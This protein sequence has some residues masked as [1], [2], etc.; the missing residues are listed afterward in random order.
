MDHLAALMAALGVLL[1][2]PGA[3][4]VGT[5]W[6]LAWAALFRRSRRTR[7]AVQ[8]SSTFAILIPAH[9]EEGTLGATLDACRSLDYPADRFSIYVIADN[10]ADCTAE[11]ARAHGVECFERTDP[12][13]RGKGYA[14]AY[15]LER[16]DLARHDAVVVLDADC[17]IDAHAL[18]AFDREGRAGGPV[19]QASYRA[20]NPDASVISYALAVGNCTENEL[21]YAPKSALGGVVLLRGT[22]MVLPRD[23]LRR[24]P[25]QA[26][27]I[28]EDVE[29]AVTLLRGGIRI[30]FVPDVA[31]HSAFPVDREQLR[32]QRTRWASGNLGFARRNV[33]RLMVDGWRTGDG[34]LWD[35]GATFLILSR[36]LVLLALL[37]PLG[38]AV[39][40]DIATSVRL[41]RWVWVAAAALLALLLAYFAL[42]VLRLGLTRRRLGLLLGAPAVLLQLA[43]I[44]VAGLLRGPART[45]DRTPRS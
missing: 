36:P 23:V 4:I 39:A 3:A 30:R 24:F 14:L 40:G 25:W 38:L 16:I 32:V 20:S 22:G 28:V 13:R 35:A 15:A 37:L 21:F 6:F 7:D 17:R 29:Y 5:Y 31:V 8:P 42:G 2:L 12:E 34:A 11:V 19:L 27:S 33:L 1:L 44:A 10:C 9:D 43:A 26:H 41:F 45:W 18:R